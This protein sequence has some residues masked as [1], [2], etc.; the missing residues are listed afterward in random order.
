MA[1]M[2]ADA[3]PPIGL[4]TYS[5]DNREQWRET[6]TTALEM[7]YRHIDTAQVYGNETYVGEGIRDSSVDR[8]EI[9]LATKTVHHDIPERA[10]D[11]GAAIDGCLDRL[12]VDYVDLLYVHWPTG[13]YEHD[14]VLPQFQAAYEDGKTRYIGLSN[15]TPKLIEEATDFLDAPI[16]A[17]QVE[18]HPLLQQA[19]L[20][21]YTA[22]R[23]MWL[24]S[25]SPLAQGDIF[26]VP[27]LREIADNHDT[28]PAQV[29]LAWNV[30]PDH[31]TAIPKASSRTHLRENLN[32]P[33]LELAPDDL[34]RIEAIDREHRVIDPDHGPWNR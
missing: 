9:F 27:D 15:F 19:A 11:A 25:Y 18:R 22:S 23:D 1:T 10:E 3:L 26:D 8:D 30:A 17:C 29:S 28:S 6:V 32:A 13:I 14:T 4:G 7:G 5:D 20:V 12:G 24:V 2:P 21:D 31:V 16:L 33:E 34:A